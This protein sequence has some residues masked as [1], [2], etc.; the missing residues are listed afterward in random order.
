VARQPDPDE[1]S[2]DAARP[3]RRGQL[4]GQPTEK[5]DIR[6]AA[7]LKEMVNLGYKAV[8][9]GDRDLTMGTTTS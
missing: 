8:S 5:G 1:L 6:T 7:L 4:L 2:G 3:P 9:V